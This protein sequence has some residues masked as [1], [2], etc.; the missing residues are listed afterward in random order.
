MSIRLTDKERKENDEKIADMLCKCGHPKKSH[1]RYTV[2]KFEGCNCVS[3]SNW[4]TC[5][6]DKFEWDGK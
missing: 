6:C 4:K 2:D 3:L 5:T 1:N